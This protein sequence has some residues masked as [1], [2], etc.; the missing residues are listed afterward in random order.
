MP[1][2]QRDIVKTKVNLPDGQDL[3][4]PC[5]IISCELANGHEDKR[6]YCG[7]MITH[8]TKKDRF[9]KPITKEMIEGH[10]EDGSQQIRLHILVTFRE[11]DISRDSTHYMGRMKKEHFKSVIEDIKSFTLYID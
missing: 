5:L 11:S 10:W 6:R 1:F 7:V 4:H 3:S 2:S 8:S 9:S